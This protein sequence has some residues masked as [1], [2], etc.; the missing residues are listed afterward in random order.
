MKYIPNHKQIRDWIEQGLKEDLGEG[1]ITTESIVPSD[2]EWDAEIIAKERV[3]LCG[4]NI[5]KETF[6]IL[7]PETRFI[8]H[9]S[10]GNVSQPNEKILTI[11]GKAQ[12]LLKGERT[13]LNILQRLSGIATL[14]N[15]FVKLVGKIKILDTRKTT[16]GL[17]I[18]EKYAVACGGAENHRFGLFD[19]IM[20]K[21]NHIRAAGSISEAVTKVRSNLD[22][23]FKIEVEATNFEEVNEALA[24]NVDRIMLDNM[25]LDE[26]KNAVDQ[27]N[28]RAEIE[29]SGGINKESVK[30]MIGL[31]VDYISIGALTHSA[32]AADISMRFL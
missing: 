1:D 31:N 12:V 2:L 29:V 18:F 26:M 22:D 4:I 10:D 20:I 19:A 5:F 21:D 30:N 13:A 7:D 32:K 25:S 6:L 23:S 14:T 27:I 17:R 16:P 15:E 24:C 3:V 28:K 9:Y 8:A 11:K